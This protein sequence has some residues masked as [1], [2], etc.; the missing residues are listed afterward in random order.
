MDEYPKAARY[1][2]LNRAVMYHGYL[3]D[4]KLDQ[5]RTCMCPVIS[6]F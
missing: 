6:T 5:Y 1:P 3:S 4:G 2:V